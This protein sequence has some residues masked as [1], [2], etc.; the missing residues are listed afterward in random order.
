LLELAHFGQLLGVVVTKLAQELTISSAW[1]AGW[2]SGPEFGV[3]GEDR[4]NDTQTRCTLF[5]RSHLVTRRAVVH[6]VDLSRLD[7]GFVLLRG[8]FVLHLNFYLLCVVCDV[9]AQSF[10]VPQVRSQVRPKLVEE[11]LRGRDTGGFDALPSRILLFEVRQQRA[12]QC[13]V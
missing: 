2:S 6:G 3:T 12:Q 11:W 10:L 4:V 8:F 13:R 1:V 9:L 7:R 5:G